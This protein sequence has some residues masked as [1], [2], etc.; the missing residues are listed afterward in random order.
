MRGNTD[1]EICGEKK[2]R[3]RNSLNIS[4]DVTSHLTC[5]LYLSPLQYHDYGN[6]WDLRQVADRPHSGLWEMSYKG[7]W[8]VPGT[9]EMC[10]W[11]AQSSS[12]VPAARDG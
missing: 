12:P 4:E 1:S 7:A 5:C 3:I 11:G 9:E 8:S 10:L 6:A 2:G